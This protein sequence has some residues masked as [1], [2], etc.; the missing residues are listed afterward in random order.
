[1]NV[2]RVGYAVMV[3]L[4]G[5]ALV[6]LSYGTLTRLSEEDM[7]RMIATAGNRAKQPEN[8]TETYGLS[9]EDWE[10]L[11]GDWETIREGGTSEI[12]KTLRTVHRQ[13]PTSQT[14]TTVKCENVLD[15]LGYDLRRYEAMSAEERNEFEKK[16]RDRTKDTCDLQ[17]LEEALRKCLREAG[18][19]SGGAE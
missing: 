7:I 13:G 9:H 1:M 18:K 12:A 11:H 19:C 10:T 17:G 14:A 5:L 2:S 3:G 4:Q 6:I 8:G 15:Q 16:V